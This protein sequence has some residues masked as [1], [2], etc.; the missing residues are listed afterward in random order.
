MLLIYLMQVLSDAV[1][2]WAMRWNAMQ[3]LASVR[4]NPKSA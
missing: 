1:V 2:E 3:W 4:I